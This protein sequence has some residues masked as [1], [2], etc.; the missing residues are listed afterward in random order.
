MDNDFLANSVFHLIGLALV[1]IY[2]LRNNVMNE[3][4]T[5]T[6]NMKESEATK[7]FGMA[8]QTGT[9]I[10]LS[11][12]IIVFCLVAIAVSVLQYKISDWAYDLSKSASTP[13]KLIEEAGP[14]SDK[15]GSGSQL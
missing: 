9:K 7:K 8:H 5:T 2:Y 10:V 11:I 4:L 14:I 3:F 12:I 6:V 13:N 15:L 1:A